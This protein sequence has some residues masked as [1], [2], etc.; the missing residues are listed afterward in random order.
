MALAAELYERALFTFG[1][2]TTSAFRQDLERGQARLDFRRPENR[3]F[4]LAGYYNLGSLLRKGTFRTALEWAK[5][6]FAMDL[7]DPF[8]MRH[9]IHPLAIRCHAAGWLS[10]F[11]EELEKL[12]VYS[13]L[14]YISQTSILAKLQNGEVE[15]A[16]EALIKGLKTVPWLYCSLFQEL[17]LDTPP[18]IWGL[19][20][21]SSDTRKFWTGLYIAQ[22]KDLWKN[23]QARDLLVEV[24]KSQDR[25]DIKHLPEDDAEIDL[26]SGRLVY[27]EGLKS[28]I[29]LLPPDMH[30]AQP[31]YDFDPMPPVREQN[32]FTS[33]AGTLPWIRM[34]ETEAEEVGAIMDQLRDFF[35]SGQEADANGR[36]SD[37]LPFIMPDQQMLDAAAASNAAAAAADEDED[38]E[39]AYARR[40]LRE[41]SGLL[42]EGMS[43]LGGG[44]QYANVLRTLRRMFGLTQNTADG[45]EGGSGA[46]GGDGNEAN[47]GDGN[48]ANGGDGNEA[49]GGD[50]N[51]ANDGGAPPTEP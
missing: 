28:L 14:V 19:S 24:T 13:D 16:R 45:G 46:N 8:G 43:G 26:A 29:T 6:L 35:T 50:G 20:A 15:E 1:R 27:L 9:F 17:N 4:W 11:L 10:D 21:D 39:I 40:V 30:D 23:R 31:N 38:E 32:I 18:A 47:G 3:Q 41:D 2:V 51:Q 12:G 42:M 25:I 5:L 44:G 49:N 7:G 36:A 34:P 22:T 48:E 33:E 37:I